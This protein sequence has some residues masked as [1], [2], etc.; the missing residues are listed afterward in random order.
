L[1]PRLYLARKLVVSDTSR[2]EDLMAAKKGA[3]KGAKKSK[4][5]AKRKTSKKK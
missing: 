4:K 2:E 5:T 1:D 3:K